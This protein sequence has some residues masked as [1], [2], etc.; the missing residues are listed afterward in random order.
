[1]NGFAQFSMNQ[2]Y[3]RAMESDAE[4][5]FVVG[6]EV[7]HYLVDHSRE[8]LRIVGVS[9]LCLLPIVPF[10]VLIRRLRP[11]PRHAIK[12]LLFVP[13]VATYLAWKY[14][15]RVMEYEADLIGLQLMSNAG[16]DTEGAIAA[17]QG[18]EDYMNRNV[19][20][21]AQWMLDLPVNSHPH[22]STSCYHGLT[23]STLTQ[24]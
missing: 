17:M 7:A 21:S 15:S 19:P 1:M 16:Y 20:P 11:R 18:L 13:M 10:A 23:I 22:V 14:M 6:H 4:L 12:G 2:G 3:L 24:M 5:A 8:K 9:A